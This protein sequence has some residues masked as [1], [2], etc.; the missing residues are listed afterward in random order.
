[1]ATKYLLKLMAG[2]P[3]PLTGGVFAHNSVTVKLPL[4]LQRRLVRWVY[5]QLNN[6]E[7]CG[8]RGWVS[9]WDE[10]A[11]W[12]S[13]SSGEWLSNTR[14]GTWFPAARECKNKL[15]PARRWRQVSS[16]ASPE[17]RGSRSHAAA[18][19]C[20][21]GWMLMFP[22]QSWEVGVFLNAKLGFGFLCALA[23][24]MRILHYTIY[25]HYLLST[26]LFILYKYNI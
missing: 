24:Q 12:V 1:M 22:K 10:T 6:R 15:T 3:Q 2:L 9:G 18:C 21:L 11:E 5:Y 8:G 23:S 16:S 14:V 13:S 19:V 26:A 4:L 25:I 17:H 20:S 7:E